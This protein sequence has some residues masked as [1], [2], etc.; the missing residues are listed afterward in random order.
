MIKFFNILSIFILS[1]C[2]NLIYSKLEKIEKIRGVNIGG[3]MVLEPWITP[4]LFYQSLGLQ[5]NIPMD[6]YSFCKYLGPVEANRQLKLHWDNWV[7]ENDIIK[8]A[9]SGI[10]VLR[11]PIGDWMYIP[12]GP[13]N[14]T[15]FNTKCTDG[16]L[17]KMDWIFSIASKHN[18][19]IILDLH[20]VSGSQ[21]G[22]DNSGQTLQLYVK[23]DHFEHWNIRSANWIG[24]FN[25]YTKQY[26]TFNYASINHS[27][28][29]LEK[30]II[31]YS[32][33]TLYPNLYGI[34]VLNEPWEF[35]PETF[36]KNFYQKIFNIF[37]KHMNNNVAF[38]FHD[39]FR[40]SI[41]TNYKIQNNFKSHPIFIDTHQYTAWNSPYESFYALLSSTSKWQAPKTYYPYI[42]G[43]FSLAIDNCEMWLNGF[44]DNIPGYPK[45]QCSY[46]SCPKN[47]Y[48]SKSLNNYYLARS[49]Y[50]PWG[51]GHS[52]PE[53][54]TYDLSG[55]LESSSFEC[56]TSVNFSVHFPHDN[57]FKYE[58][59]L[60]ISIFESK[61]KA[62]E[63]ETKGWIFWNFKTDSS[64]YQWDYLSYLNLV[65]STVVE[66]APEQ[67]INDTK[68]YMY[69]KIFLFLFGLLI[70]SSSIF[71]SYKYRKNINRRYRYIPLTR[72]NFK[73]SIPFNSMHKIQLNI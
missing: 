70:F 53:P 18:L 33:D 10:N 54:K 30:I 27:I 59:N 26:D 57:L 1:I 69:Y 62:F 25:Q 41:W 42:I 36:L 50:G 60:G 6:M 9:N 44:M 39:S 29:V 38:I 55:F 51:T 2:T 65:N 40:T 64:S 72:T 32:D 3:W 46:K 8:L 16:S 47:P 63:K 4:T 22:Y 28:N 13:Y 7:T 34:T 37:T 48:I 67:I 20:A 45:F 61:I 58:N 71:F 31:K 66:Y 17:D 49:I 73:E 19:Q 11:I 12:Y 15:K 5:D 43:E 21:N 14:V 56:P 52:S 68:S 35:T 24:S 23:G